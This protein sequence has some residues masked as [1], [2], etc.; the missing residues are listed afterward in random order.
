VKALKSIKPATSVEPEPALS[1]V[2]QKDWHAWLDAHHAVSTGVWLQFS[3]RGAAT[4]SI[5]HAEALEVALCYGWIDSQARSLD[6]G[7]WLQRFTP[8]GARSIWSKINREKVGALIESGAMKPA[9]LAEIDRAKQDGRWDAAYDAQSKAVVPDDLRV[10]LDGNPTAAAFFTTLGSK[11]RYAI[12]FRIHTAKKAETRAHRIDQF[13]RM[14][15]KH[16]T[17][18]P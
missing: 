4:S 3:K 5:N 17:I 6:A 1:F 13:V 2:I 7:S 8:R 18:Y 15:E 10:A 12:L 11:N 16:E 14:L 9:G